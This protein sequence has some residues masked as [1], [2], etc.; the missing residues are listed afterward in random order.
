MVVASYKEVTRRF[1]I[2]YTRSRPSWPP[3]S[4][5]KNVS[6]SSNLSEETDSKH[7]ALWSSLSLVAAKDSQD[8]R[9]HVLGGVRV[10]D[11]G[12]LQVCG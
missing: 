3:R 8:Q 4:K 9:E 7:C 5:M 12:A 6:D 2:N 11:D 1:N 10:Q